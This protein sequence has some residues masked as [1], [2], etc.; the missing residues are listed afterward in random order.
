MRLN[1][2]A[3]QFND[4]MDFYC[5]YIQEAHPDDGWQVQHNLDDDI[6]LNTPNTIEERAD[7][8]EVCALRL[9]MAMPMLL[10]DMTDQADK[11]YNALPER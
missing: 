5:V 2:I 4:R 11:L 9:N 1:E 3:T 7:I 10:D 6:I 8:A